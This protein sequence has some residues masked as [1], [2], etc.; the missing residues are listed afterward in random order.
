MNTEIVSIDSPNAIIRA[1]AILRSGG[2]IAFPTDTVYGV[3]VPV[4]D[5]N[6]ITKL[7]EAKKRPVD[8]AIPVLIGKTQQLD[9]VA[10]I[11][12][13]A[14][15][16]LMEKFWPGPLTLV[17]PKHHNLPHNLSAYD[18]VGVRM[19]DYHFTLRLLNKTGPLA[20]TSANISGMENS[21]SAR[22][23]YEQLGGR[24]DLILDGGHTPG[25]VPST[26]VDFSKKTPRILREGTI[27][28]GV[29]LNIILPESTQ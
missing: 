22:E 27:P 12:P 19:P 11:I 7:H 8:K 21:L 4:F 24:I 26:M 3:A 23:V 14:A 2:V 15:H 20:T 10:S 25:S 28:S 9:L 29:L 6:S 13:P 16:K 17:V 1:N 18:T 5:E